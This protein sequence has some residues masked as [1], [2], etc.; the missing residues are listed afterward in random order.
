MFE[1]TSRQLGPAI[2]AGIQINSKCG[3]EP[4]N[5]TETL[6]ARMISLRYG[7]AFGLSSDIKE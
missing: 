2:N 7:P 5:T 3:G 6:A 4:K 1:A